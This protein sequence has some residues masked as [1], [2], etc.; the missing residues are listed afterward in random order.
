MGL[1]GYYVKDKEAWKNRSW[2][3]YRQIITELVA[4]TVAVGAVVLPSPYEMEDFQFIVG[5]PLHLGR[6]PRVEISLRG[7]PQRKV[8]MEVITESL[9]EDVV[10]DSDVVKAAVYSIAE[11]I[12]DLLGV[13]LER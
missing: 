12:G 7:D 4:D 9:C 5:E 11:R 13:R 3:N 2:A 1:Y 6:W 10:L 8:F